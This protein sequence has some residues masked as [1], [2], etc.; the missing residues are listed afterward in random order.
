MSAA[1][2]I[3]TY[4]STLHGPYFN[5]TDYGGWHAAYY[6]YTDD[7]EVDHTYTGIPLWMLVSCVDGEDLDHY[8][9][10]ETLATQ[11]YAV[12]ITASDGWSVTLTSAEV[13]YNDTLVIAFMFDWELLAEDKAPLRLVSQWL[14]KSM[15]ISQIVSIELIGV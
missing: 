6:N 11:G 14:S 10:N 8:Q 15:W 7:L 1:T 9:F 2:F 5:Y 12:K 4:Y 13:E 3:S